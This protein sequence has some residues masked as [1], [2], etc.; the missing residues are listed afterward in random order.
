MMMMMICHGMAVK[1]LGLLGVSV[2]KMNARTVK[3]ET[4]ALIG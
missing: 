2:R 1:M 4:V 3:M